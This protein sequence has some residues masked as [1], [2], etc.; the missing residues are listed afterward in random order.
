MHMKQFL[1]TLFVVLVFT[2]PIWGAPSDPLYGI[3]GRKIQY[4]TDS[5]NLNW[6]VDTAKHILT[7]TGSGPMRD[8]DTDTRAPWYPWRK[9]IQKVI[10]PPGMTTVGDYAMYDLQELTDI[11]WT[12]NSKVETINKRAFGYC[13]S[14]PKLELPNSVSSIEQSAF[15]RCNSLKSVKMGN[16]V[17]TIESEAFEYC[18]SI[19]TIDFGESPAIIGPWAFRPARA[20]KSIKAKKIK[21]IN[22]YA[23]QD[24]GELV[25]LEL[26]DSLKTIGEDAF[27]GCKVLPA[28][29]F[30][31]TLTSFYANSFLLCYALDTITVH[32]DNPIYNSNNNCNAAILTA[33]NKVVLG[34]W[35]SV[36][37]KETTS[38]GEQAFYAC[39]RL[40]SI[41]LPDG[42]QSIEEEAFA[43]CGQLQSVYLPNS[44]TSIGCGVF[45]GCSE[46]KEPV[47]NSTYFVYLNPSYEGEYTIPDSPKRI[48]CQAF[49]Q[50]AK[51]TKINIPS[52]V[53]DVN[54]KAFEYCTD[55]QQAPLPHNLT[56]L[57]SYAFRNCIA[58]SSIIIPDRIKTI[59]SYTFSN[60]TSLPSI[61]IPDSVKT[62][63]NN[64]F[65]GCSS[66]TSITFPANLTSISSEILLRCTNLDT[67]NW[68]V[69]TYNTIDISYSYWDPFNGIRAQLT[70]FIFGDSV[71]VI[72]KN[73]CYEMTGLTSMSLGC[74]IGEI[75]DNAF[76]GCRNIK[77]I[78]W[79]LRTCKDPLI[80]TQAPFYS[81]R[82]S[83]TD[84]TFGDSVRHIPAYLCHSMRRL[85]QIHIPKNVSS[86]AP[87]AFRYLGVLDSISV[88]EENRWYDSRNHCNALIETSSNILMLGCYKTQIPSDMEGIGDCAFRNV[89]GLNT[90]LLPEGVTFV[91]EEAFNGCQDLQE[92]TL[93]DNIETIDNYAFQDCS[94]L[95][96]LE[97]PSKLK[98]L[99]FRAFAHCSGLESIKCN[100]LT[101]PAIDET[102]FS[103][104]HC[105]IYV[106]CAQ[107]TTYRNA[108]VWMDYGN[109]LAGEYFFTLTIRPN[110][111]AS[112]VVTMIQQPDCEH[113]AIIEAEPLYGYGFKSWQDEAGQVLS[114]DARYEFT[115]TEDLDLIAVFERISEGL[116]DITMGNNESIWYDIMGHRIEQPS[117]SGI[118][119]VV[120][121]SETRKI[122]IP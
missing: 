74:N 23:F 46:L 39:P 47:Y 106:P 43:E 13:T 77:H 10:F 88:A 121:G 68:N 82:D 42:L 55:L 15:Y 69:R 62:I 27:N 34:C 6:V 65:E 5:A 54:V 1:L 49:S 90:V 51:L 119:I 30:P 73:L 59:C 114:T 4:N 33:K 75:K 110:E 37:P 22:S 92:L 118:Y 79:N 101:P 72:P 97:L 117:S 94:S 50:C 48:A 9:F 96:V 32:P 83:I 31:A 29:H 76:Y 107:I 60:C 53:T 98:R 52:S 44:V 24:C 70:T 35:Q 11:D 25:H 100:A 102:S 103:D 87:F 115:L 21:V 122:F 3:C 99:G 66:L 86:I 45:Y 40:Y 26:G 7:I 116:D 109:R 20:L 112:G 113:A 80:Y 41:S 38:I 111:Y 14:L 16:N 57:G 18:S 61:I 64:A 91:G 12:K 85:H 56:Y 8:Y 17:S 108:P 67:I 95:P 81:L 71:R 2:T 84:F 105:P 78:H 63:S 19:E 104:T 58:L 89:R 93:S 36:I 28:I 120:T